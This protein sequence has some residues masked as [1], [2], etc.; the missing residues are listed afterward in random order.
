MGVCV[1]VHA[2][3]YDAE[4]LVHSVHGIS[5]P[6]DSAGSYDTFNTINCTAVSHM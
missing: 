3:I 1:C 2:D 5:V 6:R 4:P